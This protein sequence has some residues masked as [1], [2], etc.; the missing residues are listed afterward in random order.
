MLY[1]CGRTP[2]APGQRFLT[3]DRF[4]KEE[5]PDALPEG[6]CL[7]LKSLKKDARSGRHSTVVKVD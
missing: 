4:L 6:D 3:N 7:K 2:V 5:C 1:V